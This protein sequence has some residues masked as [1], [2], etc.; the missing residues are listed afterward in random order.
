[1]GMLGALPMKIMATELELEITDMAQT[2]NIHSASHWSVSVKNALL[3][4]FKA[5]LF[6]KGRN[7]SLC[8]AVL[9]HSDLDF[10]T[11]SEDN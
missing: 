2:L 5:A 1:M 11:L 8:A 9:R 6:S 4:H 10:S 7:G 3:K